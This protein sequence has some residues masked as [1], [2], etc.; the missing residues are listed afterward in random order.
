ME[1]RTDIIKC[2]SCGYEEPRFVAPD[3]EAEEDLK[4]KKHIGG[5]RAKSCSCETHG[6]AVSAFAYYDDEC[7]IHGLEG[8]D[9]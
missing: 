6:E 7:P 3:Q 1:G 5:R 4:A 9:S 2:W 8:C